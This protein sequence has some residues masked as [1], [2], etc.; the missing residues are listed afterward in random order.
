MNVIGIIPARYE[1]TR[2]PGKPLI[3]INGKSM[4]CR[5]YEQV[6]RS[7]LINKVIIATDDERIEAHAGSFN[8]EVIMTSTKHK[9]G[10]DRCYEAARVLW[11]R[12]IISSDDIVINI[13]GDEPFINP[14]QINSLAKC[15]FDDN[16]NIATLVKE[17]DNQEELQNHNVVKVV[18][19]KNNEA[20]YFSRYAIPFNRNIEKND[21]IAHSKYYKHIGMYGY[22]Y[23]TLCELALLEPTM[24]EKSESLEQLRWIENAYKIYTEKTNHESISIDTPE[25][26]KK[27]NGLLF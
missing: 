5:V 18:L 25:D 22:R 21:W 10:T 27:I 3:D 1:S 23:K 8:A 7:M 26:L 14:E 4:I 12:Q 11:A 20:I 24:L 6:K 2:F 17:I 9:T 15:F 13:Q 19:N 16:V